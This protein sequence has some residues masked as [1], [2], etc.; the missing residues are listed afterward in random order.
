MKAVKFLM[1]PKCCCSTFWDWRFYFGGG[2]YVFVPSA[3]TF[4]SQNSP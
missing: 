3:R 1:S 4:L 2:V